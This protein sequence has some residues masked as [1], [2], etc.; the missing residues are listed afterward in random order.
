MVCELSQDA[1]WA[2]G[3]KIV[4]P[5]GVTLLRLSMKEL[6]NALAVVGKLGPG[7]ST[8]TKEETQTGVGRPEA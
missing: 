8:F 5:P 6:K 2:G 3:R 4:H 1:S 7:P